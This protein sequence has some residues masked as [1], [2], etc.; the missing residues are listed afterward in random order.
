[1]SAEDFTTYQKT[2]EADPASKHEL[3]L[4]IVGKMSEFCSIGAPAAVAPE[5]KTTDETLPTV[6]TKVEN[7][8]VEK[9]TDVVI[10][11]TKTGCPDNSACYHS[12]YSGMGPNGLV[13]GD[14]KGDLKCHLKCEIDGDCSQG[15]VCQKVDLT[16]GDVVMSQ[17][18]CLAK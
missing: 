13:V 7:E 4:A 15:E 16:G 11:C 12:Q 10:D 9:N 1:V 2:I 17:Q 3:S 14:E 6:D 8:T 18:F 5:T